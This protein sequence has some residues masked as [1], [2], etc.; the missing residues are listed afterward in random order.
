ERQRNLRKI[1]EQEANYALD[2]LFVPIISAAIAIAVSARETNCGVVS[3]VV[4]APVFRICHHRGIEG[5]TNAR[6]TNIFFLSKQFV[7]DCTQR[8]NGLAVG[9]GKPWTD[10]QNCEMILN[11]FL[12]SH[13]RLVVSGM[14]FIRQI[15]VL[16]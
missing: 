16:G 7:F 9:I 13:A 2:G 10:L 5:F 12:E 15:W 14:C 6:E 3:V 4:G 11:H 1:G 8:E